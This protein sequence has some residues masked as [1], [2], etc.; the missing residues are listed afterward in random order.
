MVTKAQLDRAIADMGVRIESSQTEILRRLDMAMEATRL[1][2]D[3]DRQMFLE[4]LQGHRVQVDQSLH[5]QFVDLRVE[6]DLQHKPRSASPSG[7][8]RSDFILTKDK[9]APDLGCSSRHPPKGLGGQRTDQYQ[10]LRADYPDFSEENVVEWVR[11]CNSYF[12]MHQVPP[13]LKT[14]LAT[15]QFSG[16]TI[17]WYDCFLINYDPPD[18]GDLV[19]RVRKRFQLSIS[20]NGI[21]ELMELH[22][23]SSVGEYIERF[24]RLHT[25][26]LL[27]NR[28]FS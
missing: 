2:M 28:L 16:P 7:V 8:A 24:E 20:K 12:E 10:P 23:T 18:W 22:Q 13:N 21:E 25:K 26:L 27:K 14:K 6:M 15:M 1:Q 19:R 9:R 3:Q 5:Q 11:K 17:E 4:Q